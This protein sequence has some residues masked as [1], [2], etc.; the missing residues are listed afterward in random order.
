MCVPPASRG[1]PTNGG[2]CPHPTPT[3]LRMSASVTSSPRPGHARCRGSILGEA[4]GPQGDPPVVPSRD[5]EGPTVLLPQ[6]EQTGDPQ[7]NWAVRREESG[8][9]LAQPSVAVPGVGLA[10]A[11]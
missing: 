9:K 7:S 8:R 11:L 4:A 6:G 2:T 3:S 5:C 1:S 10:L